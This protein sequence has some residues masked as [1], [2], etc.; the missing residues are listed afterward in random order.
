MLFYAERNEEITAVYVNESEHVAAAGTTTIVDIQ[1]D[2]TNNKLSFVSMSSVPEGYNIVIGGIIA[3]T[4]ATIGTSGD[5]FNADTATY[6]RGRSSNAASY[7]YT[8]TKPNVHEGDTWYA[9]AY[10][11]YTDA[12]ENVYTVYGDLVTVTF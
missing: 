9:R 6:V 3:T 8:W 12:D 2:T 1:K 5:G 10:L 4:D 7:R 11:V